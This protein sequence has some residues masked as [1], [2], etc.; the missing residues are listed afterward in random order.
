MG[1]FRDLVALLIGWKS[2]AAGPPP[3]FET[4]AGRVWHSG[5]AAGRS[6]IT[7]PRA[8]QV[9]TSGPIAGQIHG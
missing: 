1:G 8:G 7:G 3:S 6:F 5:A 9:H 4:V 2:A